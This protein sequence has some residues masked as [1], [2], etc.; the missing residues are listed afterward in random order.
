M[1]FCLNFAKEIMDQQK[2]YR[3]QGGKFIAP[4]PKVTVA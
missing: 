4:I 3:D 1:G 2:D